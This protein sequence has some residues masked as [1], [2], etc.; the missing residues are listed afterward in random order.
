MRKGTNECTEYE[1]KK[2]AGFRSWIPFFDYR[3]L[4]LLLLLR[5]LFLNPDQSP[6]PFLFLLFL[7]AREKRREEKRED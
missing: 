5:T 6:F 3:L 7:F 2:M 4:L 1:M